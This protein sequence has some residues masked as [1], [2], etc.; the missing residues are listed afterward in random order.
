MTVVKT[1]K[2]DNYVIDTVEFWKIDSY[3]GVKVLTVIWLFSK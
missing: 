2:N 1:E 3:Y